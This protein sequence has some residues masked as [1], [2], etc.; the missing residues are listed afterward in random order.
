MMTT[1]QQNPINHP[2]AKALAKLLAE[3]RPDWDE[4]GTMAALEGARQRAGNF[5][6]T[7]AAIRAAATPTVRTPA[8]I[9]MDGPHWHPEP[10]PPKPRTQPISVVSRCDE[11]GGMHTP[12]DE[13]DPP[14]QRRVGHDA[15]TEYAH[16]RAALRA[17][18]H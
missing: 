14:E 8:V 4:R 2:Q 7:L 1:S 11:C 12:E 6:L 10:A 17:G 5:D 9:G 16:A 13:H 18:G 3:L 15:V